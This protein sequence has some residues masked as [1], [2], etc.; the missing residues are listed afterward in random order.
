MRK[1]AR[2]VRAARCKAASAMSY[3]L[4]DAEVERLLRCPCEKDEYGD[5]PL[6]QAAYAGNLAMCLALLM[7]GADINARSDSK[8]WTALYLASQQG[9][10]TVVALL[11]GAGCD[12]EIADVHGISALYTA[13]KHGNSVAV[14]MLLDH[15]CDASK[16]RVNGVT[17]LIAACHKGHTLVIELLLESPRCSVDQAQDNGATALCIA[18]QMGHV[19]I[20][21]MLL[22]Q[23]C[24]VDAGR[25]DGVTP[26]YWAC[27]RGYTTIVRYLLDKGCAVNQTRRDGRSPLY[28]ASHRGDEAVVT[29]LLQRGSDVGL[30]CDAEGNTALSASCVRGH[31]EVAALLLK[32]G[33]AEKQRLR[34]DERT[35]LH[36][37]VQHGHVNCVDVLTTR[38]P[39]P[40]SWHVFLVGCASPTALHTYQDH[41]DHRDHCSDLH[42][43]HT[44]KSTFSRWNLLPHI[45]VDGLIHLIWTFLH[46]PCYIVDLDAVESDGYTALGIAAMQGRKDIVSL[47]RANGATRG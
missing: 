2:D 43:V 41:R 28:V 33:A 45:Y 21:M 6:L 18:C 47:L 14:V 46:K 13:S 16:A 17:P 38:A 42:T 19:S 5:G 20:A 10:G 44:P 23:G 15:G 3:G 22:D 9:H 37:A 29:M 24:D 26:L 25:H 4:D 12:A 27:E 35:L 39:S 31:A 7:R 30:I 11:L 1:V 8:G 40:P 32:A 36:L 34:R